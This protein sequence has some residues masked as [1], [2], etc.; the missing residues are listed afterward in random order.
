MKNRSF[1][2]V[3][4]IEQSLL[5]PPS[6]SSREKWKFYFLYRWNSAFNPEW[7]NFRA[8]FDNKKGRSPFESIRPKFE[9]K[10]L[11]YIITK[12]QTIF[13]LIK[14]INTPFERISVFC[15][16]CWILRTFQC[17]QIMPFYCF[18]PDKIVLSLFSG[19]LPLNSIWTQSKMV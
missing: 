7:Y 14:M 16:F 12:Y 1:V 10:G 2:K 18:G 13:K 8:F 15:I 9:E 6:S 19:H 3:K 17:K 5:S 11:I 4:I